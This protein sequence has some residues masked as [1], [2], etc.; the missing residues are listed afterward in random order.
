MVIVIDNL[1]GITGIYKITNPVGK[2]YI[3]QST[4]IGGRKSAYRRLKCE[5]QLRLYNSLLKYGY[6]SHKFELIASC[7]QAELNE[8]EVYYINTYDAINKG[9]NCLSGGNNNNIIPSVRASKSAQLKGNKYALGF[10]H[11]KETKE[12]M[13]QAK[14]GIVLSEETRN[15]IGEKLKGN[16]NG[17]NARRKGVID[18]ISGCVYSSIVE[19]GEANGIKP[20]TLNNM[21]AGS[22][23]NIT[24]L[25]YK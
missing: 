3:G 24:S 2:V 14:T 21:L 4:N 13:S 22:R 7:E 16:R 20:K 8:L 19:A 5:K 6:D 1:H 25:R 15:R 23:K 9:L 10:K 12:R 17:I 11:T 18:I